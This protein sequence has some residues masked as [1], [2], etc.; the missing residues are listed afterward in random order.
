MDREGVWKGRSG[1]ID[2]VQD[3]VVQDVA[4]ARVVNYI[5]KGRYLVGRGCETAPPV[6]KNIGFGYFAPV[7]EPI[8]G[9]VRDSGGRLIMHA[10]LQSWHGKHSDGAIG[11]DDYTVVTGLQLGGEDQ[12]VYALMTRALTWSQDTLKLDSHLIQVSD[13]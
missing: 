11:N 1:H 2:T 8:H 6:R 9:F 3:I 13:T 4:S 7:R 10:G 12:L 5:D